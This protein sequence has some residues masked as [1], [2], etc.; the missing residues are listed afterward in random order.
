M[1]N[2]DSED[3]I[4]EKADTLQGM[5][6]E[7]NSGCSLSGMISISFLKLINSSKSTYVEPNDEEKNYG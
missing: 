7:I 3:G 4:D 2:V 5:K 6:K 1:A